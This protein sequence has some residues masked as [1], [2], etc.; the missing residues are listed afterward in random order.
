MSHGEG[1]II[2]AQAGEERGV[3]REVS[4]EPVCSILFQGGTKTGG[5]EDGRGLPKDTAP[6]G[7][8]DSL[9]SLF[10]ARTWC[11]ALC[12]VWERK[13]HWTRCLRLPSSLSRWSVTRSALH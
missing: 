7:S 1:E 9:A 13:T 2:S 4:P 10:P 5:P 6:A 8:S 3:Q 12:A 11:L